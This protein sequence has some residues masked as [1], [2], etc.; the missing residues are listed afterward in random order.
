MHCED[1]VAPCAEV[2]PTY[3]LTPST[4]DGVVHEAAKE[5]CIA[6]A[7]CVHACPFGVPKLDMEEMLQYKCNMCYDRSSAWAHAMC[8]AVC[9]SGA[10]LLRQHRRGRS[11]SVRAPPRP[12]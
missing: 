3:V 11:R 10:T 4:A 7:N 6:C 8:A 12:T 5:R 9:P 2:C 1:P